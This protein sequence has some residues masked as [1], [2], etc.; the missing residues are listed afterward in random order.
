MRKRGAQ[1]QIFLTG[2]HR[3]HYFVVGLGLTNT[4]R[5]I[6]VKRKQLDPIKMSL[7]A[8]TA[9]FLIYQLFVFVFYGLKY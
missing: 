1:A 5:G 8:C 9:K 6:G 3:N 7:A 4:V 2:I